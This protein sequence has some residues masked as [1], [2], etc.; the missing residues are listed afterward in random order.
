VIAAR[1]VRTSA[2]LAAWE[3]KGRSP[4]ERVDCFIQMLIA[5]RV[6]IRR[7]GCPVGTLCAEL[8]KLGHPAIAEANGLFALFRLWLR[9]QFEELGLGAR[10]DALAMHLLARSQGI[11]AL[12][13]AFDDE[14][15][16]RAEVR[17]LRLWLGE[18]LARGAR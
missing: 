9:R 18:Q 17:E 3:A 15:F 11:A 16:I 14:A 2:M 5:N 13:Q 7:Y 1:L 4:A 6:P 12:A 8:G 10:A